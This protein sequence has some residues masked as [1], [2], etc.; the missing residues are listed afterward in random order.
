MPRVGL[1]HVDIQRFKV[2]MLIDIVT[3]EGKEKE[4]LKLPPERRGF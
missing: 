1:V 3:A 2:K 4:M